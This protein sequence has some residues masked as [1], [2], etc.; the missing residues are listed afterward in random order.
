MVEPLKQL[1]CLPAVEVCVKYIS[2]VYLTTNCWFLDRH[3][4]LHARSCFLNRFSTF[5]YLMYSAYFFTF[6]VYHVYLLPEPA[7]LNLCTK[8]SRI[9]SPKN[10]SFEELEFAYWRQLVEQDQLFMFTLI[11]HPVCV[12]SYKVVYYLLVKDL[13]PTILRF[14]LCIFKHFNIKAQ[15]DS[16]ISVILL[17]CSGFYNVSSCNVANVC[18]PNGNICFREQVYYCLKRANSI[19]F[20]YYSAGLCVAHDRILE[21]GLYKR[22]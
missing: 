11:C 1:L 13:Y 21:L 10:E 15:H 22:L 8:N 9:V 20:Q 3:C 2:L 4:Y 17:H 19:A 6:F 16:K 14:L 5:L 12:A 18:D 7:C